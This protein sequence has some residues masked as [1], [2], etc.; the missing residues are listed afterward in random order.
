MEHQAGLDGPD[1]TEEAGWAPAVHPSAPELGA[2]PEQDQAPEPVPNREA[3]REAKWRLERD[4][5]SE[6]AS[7][8]GAE[9][10]QDH[11]PE[12]VPNREAE[13]EAKWRLE[14]DQESEP[15]SV[16]GAEPE[17][18]QA[19]LPV[20]NREPEPAAEREPQPTLPAES[21]PATGEPRVDAALKLLDRLPSLPVSAHTELFEQ[22]HAQLS[23]VLGEL[24]SGPAGPAGG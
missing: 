17:Q 8:P 19:P 16:P 9:P 3:E 24:D 10:E 12:P 2:E 5:E 14:R 20:P 1:G 21:A 23:D 15:A 4:Q 11:A 6:A 22:V 7:V 13:P 18:D